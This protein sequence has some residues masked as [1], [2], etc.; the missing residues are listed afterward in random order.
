MRIAAVLRGKSY[1]LPVISD[2]CEDSGIVGEGCA[3][4]MNV[5]YLADSS[6]DDAGDREVRGLLSTC[7]TKPGD[8]VFRARR[9][10]IWELT[11]LP[12]A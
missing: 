6:I 3:I 4:E 10:L 11:I 7:F 9:R 8:E 2:Q 5:E 12:P 1:Q